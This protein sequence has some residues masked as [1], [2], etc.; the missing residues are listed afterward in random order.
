[1][2]HRHNRLEGK[3]SVRS[4]LII[5]LPVLAAAIVLAAGCGSNSP[6]PAPEEAG[7]TATQTIAVVE[8]ATQVVEV[9]RAVPQTVVVTATP[10]PTPAYESPIKA[11]AGTLRYPL[12]A[13]PASIDP[14]LAYDVA[15]RLIAQQLYEGLFHLRADGTTSP[16]AAIGYEAS[17]AS[18]VFT[19]TLRSGMTWS[20][21]RPV[22][23]QH[24]VDG[25]CR[26]LDPAVGND[27][28]Y[29]LTDIAPVKGA[30]LYAGGDTADCNQVAVKAV[31]DQTLRIELEGPAAFFP[32]LLAMPLFWPAVPSGP[33]PVGEPA[34]EIPSDAAA[35]ATP[36]AEGSNVPSDI[37]PPPE[38]TPGGT[39]APPIGAAPS[40]GDPT[41]AVGG[42]PVPLAPALTGDDA[43]IFNG[44]YR[45]TA[46]DPE[47]LVVL[48]KNPRYWNADAV[49]VERIELPVLPDVAEQL[50]LFEAGDLQ[51]AE[52]PA[53]ETARIQADPGLAQELKVIVQP[54]TSYIGLNTAADPTTALPLRKAIASAIDRQA[55]IRDVLEQDWHI[56]A[57]GMVP[58]NIQGF[59]GDDPA[60]GYDYN[61]ELARQFLAEAGYGPDRPAPVV[62]I[63]T[64]REGNNRLVFEA[65]S[66]MLEEVGVPVRL[67]TS[68][69]TTYLASLD[70]CNK[71]NRAGAARTPAEC[72]YNAYRMGWV[73]DYADPSAILDVVLHPNSA[74]QYTGW[75]SEDFEKLIAQARS[76]PD[77]AV[78]SELYRQAERILVT[79][80]AAVVPLQHYDRTLLVKDG[81]FAEYAPF[82]PPNLQFWTLRRQ[83]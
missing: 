1:V 34:P 30:D 7:A 58:P 2:E 50:R 83:P 28:Y 61:P 10:I 54:G 71:P 12:P 78:R 33:A 38:L 70:D 26:V 4:R 72:S 9:T 11:P 43:L 46:W 13:A 82:G 15:G 32:K 25:I 27:Y 77:E 35:G 20:D 76:E 73:L 56:A 51:V 68:G 48:E 69:W 18:D 21:G 79:D 16:A 67:A 52:F 29:L 75:Q 55:L 3:S 36:G 53:E 74:L 19:V 80:Q 31:D 59:Q 6:A 49:T 81:I 44:P 17:P 39:P 63:W 45:V 42:T 8:V 65:I 60:L 5:L 22:T 41:P 47:R 14:Q 23:A 40:P 57:R 64:N 37:A 66:E 24:Y 62:E